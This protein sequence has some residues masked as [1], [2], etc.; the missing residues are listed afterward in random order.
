[1][2]SLTIY[3]FF[4]YG[5]YL[6][7]HYLFDLVFCPLFFSNR[8]FDT[9]LIIILNLLSDNIN[10]CEYVWVL[11]WCLLCPFRLCLFS[12]YVCFI[13]FVVVEF[14]IV[15]LFYLVSIVVVIV[16]KS[17]EYCIERW[18]LVLIIFILG[19]NHAFSSCSLLMW[20]FVLIYLGI[21]LGLKFFSTWFWVY[22][23]T[24]DFPFTLLSRENSFVLSLLH[25]NVIFTQ[26]LLAC[27]RESWGHSLVF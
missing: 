2:F 25:P 20:W 26:C 16:V 17:L 14:L 9:L 7:W 11:S 13:D 10:I 5:F 12:F 3:Y 19:D 6:S 8:G 21:G 18:V 27:G 4:S 23:M 1:M 15:W 22:P 24:L